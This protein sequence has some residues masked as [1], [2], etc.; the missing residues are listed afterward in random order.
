MAALRRRSRTTRRVDVSAN[1]AARAATVGHL[2]ERPQLL[3]RQQMARHIVMERPTESAARAT[4]DA[5][6]AGAE[7]H[8]DDNGPSGD[9]IE[10]GHASARVHARMAC[11]GEP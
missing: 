8:A 9:G 6:H 7:E 11:V 2:G 3:V 5:T 10:C 1:S 4:D